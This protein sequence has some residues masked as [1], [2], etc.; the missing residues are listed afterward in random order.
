MASVLERRSDWSYEIHYIGWLKTT[1][2]RTSCAEAAGYYTISDQLEFRSVINSRDAIERVLIAR[3][4]FV[5]ESFWR[6]VRR[7]IGKHEI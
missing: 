1:L 2:P 5:V 7:F 6:N 3:N 4:R